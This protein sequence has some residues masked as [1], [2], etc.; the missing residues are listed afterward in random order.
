MIPIP[1]AGVLKRVEGLLDAQRVEFIDDV[2]IQIREGHELVPLPEG[3][4]YL[5]F[6]F[7]H[8]PTARQAEQALRNAHACLRFVIAPVWRLQ[9]GTLQHAATNLVQTGEVM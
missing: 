4:S 5:G 3:A 7:A 9:A 6:I 8:A 2:N 1:E